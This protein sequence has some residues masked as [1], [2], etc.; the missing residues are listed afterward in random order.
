MTEGSEAD[1]SQAEPEGQAGLTRRKLVQTGAAVVGA[2]IVWT[3]PFPFS[4]SRIGQSIGAEDAWA[5]GATGATGGSGPSRAGY[6][7]VAGNTHPDGTTIPPGTFLDLQLG[8][9]DWD[10][11][12]AGAQPAIYVEGKGITCDPPPTGYTQGGLYPGGDAVAG[13]YPYWRRPQ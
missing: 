1:P 9:P 10:P 12:Y 7:S 8:Q 4:R 5:A 6:C 3:S 2:S 13:F 11:H